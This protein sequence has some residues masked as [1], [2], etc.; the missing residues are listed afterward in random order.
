V[1]LKHLQRTQHQL[2]KLATCDA[3]TGLPNRR[4]FMDELSKLVAQPG[5]EELACL[6]LDLDGFKSVNDFHGHKV[7]DQ[8]LNVVARQ[9]LGC[10]RG[11]DQL[12]RLGG[13]EFTVVLRGPVSQGHARE[14]ADRIIRS[15]EAITHVDDRPVTISVS[16]G[17]SFVPAAGA[18]RRVHSDELLRAA[19]EA[20]YAAKKSGRGQQRMTDFTAGAFAPAA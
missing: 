4:F 3:L 11:S 20:M 16:I 7:G 5:R 14:V 13:D 18:G 19:D 2:K 12:A 17:I 1:L 10:I 8:L 6:Y 9:I 15:V